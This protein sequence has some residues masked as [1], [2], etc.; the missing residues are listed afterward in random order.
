MSN[1]C[2]SCRFYKMALFLLSFSFSFFPLNFDSPISQKQNGELISDEAL[3]SSAVNH[4]N[5][6]LSSC[7]VLHTHRFTDVL[8]WTKALPAL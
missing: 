4:L 3:G 1:S 7:T 2:R 5:L 8:H 6:L